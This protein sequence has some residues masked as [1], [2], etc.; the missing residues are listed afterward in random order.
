LVASL[1][2]SPALFIIPVRC[3][4]NKVKGTKY[5]RVVPS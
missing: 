4:G 3:V 5:S 1:T 2:I